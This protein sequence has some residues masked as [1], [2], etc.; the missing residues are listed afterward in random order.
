MSV[1]IYFLLKED[2]L[3]NVE[4]FKEKFN[5]MLHIRVFLNDFGATILFSSQGLKGH[6]CKA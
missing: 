1:F 5:E 3:Q 4:I 6:I 2:I